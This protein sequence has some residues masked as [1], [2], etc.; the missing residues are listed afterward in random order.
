MKIH[1]LREKTF[2]L[3]KDDNRY[4]VNPYFGDAITPLPVMPKDI[5]KNVDSVVFMYNLDNYIDALTIKGLNLNKNKDKTFYLK[6]DVDIKF[7]KSLGFLNAKPISEELIADINEF[8]N[9]KYTPTNG[10]IIFI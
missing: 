4:L 3:I 7:I 2:I 9:L 5:M 8:I 6:N 10:E 1:F